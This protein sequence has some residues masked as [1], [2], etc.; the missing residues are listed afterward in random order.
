MARTACRISHS[1]SAFPVFNLKADRR[2]S[3]R[4][5]HKLKVRFPVGATES[6]RSQIHQPSHP[7]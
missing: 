5:G 2:L 6:G 4:P 7:A 1:M 3:A